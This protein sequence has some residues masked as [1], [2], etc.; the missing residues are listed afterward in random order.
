MN[1]TLASISIVM[2]C[3]ASMPVLADSAQVQA[4]V[5]NGHD[6][7]KLSEELLLPWQAAWLSAP[8]SQNNDQVTSWCGAGVIDDHWLVTAAHCVSSDMSDQVV[9]GTHSI[10]NKQGD[11][12]NIDGKYLFRIDLKNSVVHPNYEASNG[13]EHKLDNDIA[14]IKVDR[15]M[16]DV[17]KPIRIATPQEQKDI[18]AEFEQTWN[19]TGYSKA[20]LI[21]SGWGKHGPN[22][23]QPNNLMVVKLGGIPMGKC[24][25]DY[26]I[27]K[28]SHFVCADSNT[29]ELKKD[30]CKGDSGGPL[31]WQNPA[32]A[33]DPDFGLRVIGVVSNGPL[34]QLKANGDQGAQTNGLYTELSSYYGWIEQET[35]I[36]LDNIQPTGYTVDPFKVTKDALPDGKED[37]SSQGGNNGNTN[38]VES[39]QK[40]SGGGGSLPLSGLISLTALA[41]LRRK[42]K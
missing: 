26:T 30:V 5:L 15:S 2:A 40:S 13:Y 10:R 3:A 36:Q 11:A 28:D 38:Q 12:N 33:N 31:V 27:G 24:N 20:N 39:K 9:V 32:H 21:A 1:K 34:C 14:L 16:S 8:Q 7:S 22:F 6:A 35:G 29:P 18:N 42:V 37:N 25:T 17:A 19:P 4:R 23:D 41:L